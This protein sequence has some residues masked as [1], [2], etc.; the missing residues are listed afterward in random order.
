M[1]LSTGVV[2]SP[3]LVLSSTESKLYTLCTQPFYQCLK[4]LV[5]SSEK[6]NPSGLSAPALRILLSEPSFLLKLLR[7]R[8]N[9]LNA[10]NAMHLLVTHLG[11][12]A[13]AVL[14]TRCSP[15]RYNIPYEPVTPNQSSRHP[16]EAVSRDLHSYLRCISVTITT[17]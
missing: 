3:M 4:K 12:Q 5:L 10:T 13:V 15:I 14:T 16:R 11:V 9:C 7:T 17:R 8:T 1:E 6:Q 2:N